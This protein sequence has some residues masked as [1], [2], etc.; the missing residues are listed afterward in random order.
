MTPRHPP[1]SDY[2]VAIEKACSTIEPNSAEELRA[3]IRGALKHTIL[4]RSNINREEV[5]ALVELRRDSSK[6]ILTADKQVAL[7]IID[8]PDYNNKAQELLNDKTYKEINTDPTNKLKD[9]T[10]KAIKE[11]QGRRGNRRTAVQ[12][13][14][15]HRG[16]GTKVLWATQDP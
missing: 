1:Y 15:P 13:D 2:I 4:P 16:C 6:V 7:V 14:V 5:Q 11:D 12:E 10:Y 3:K 9:Q 8:N